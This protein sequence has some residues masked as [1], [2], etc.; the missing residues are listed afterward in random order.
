MNDSTVSVKDA[1][2]EDVALPASLHHYTSIDSLALILNSRT[3]RLSRLDQVDDLREGATADYKRLAHYTFTTCWTN[4]PTESIPFWHMYTP[5]MA[6]VRIT[7]PTPFFKTYEVFH[8]TRTGNIQ[9]PGSVLPYDKLVQQRCLILAGQA[10]MFHPV[11]YTEDESLLK[12]AVCTYDQKGDV[13]S[14]SVGKIG[15][16]KSS[17]WSFQSEWR[18]RIHAL[19]AEID[20]ISELDEY[21][22]RMVARL[23]ADALLRNTPPDLTEIFLDIDENAF[24]KMKLTTGPKMSEGAKLAVAALVAAYNPTADIVTSSLEGTIR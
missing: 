6:G 24:S 16:H 21:D 17:A 11:I 14:I 5:N 9:L 15:V 10:H 2:S 3:L 12:P 7:L 23:M 4:E 1:A 20:H 22:A 13:R 19:P 18:Y 8:D